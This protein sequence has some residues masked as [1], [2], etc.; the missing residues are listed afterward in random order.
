MFEKCEAIVMRTIDY[1]ETNKIVTLFTREWGKVA[2]MA[3]GAKKPSSRL[4]AVTQP[5]A[6]GHYLIRRSR[7]VGVLHQGELIDSMRALR[8][9]LFAAAYA[10]Y[11]VEL[12]DKSTEEQKRN[13]YLFELLRQT[14]QYMSEG[15]DL[16]IMALIYEMKM[17]PV[18]GIPPVLDRCARCGA[19]EGSV[20]F[21]VK[22]AGFLCHRCEEADPHR[23]PLSPASARLLRLFFHIDLAR[24]GAIS[25]KETTKAE[26]KAVLS[27]YYDEYAGLSLKA[28]RFLQQMSV[29][30][31]TL[32]PDSGQD[33]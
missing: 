1:G 28:K 6:Y 9:D 5:L 25:V 15:R 11:I 22:E 7:G 12:T 18:L 8:E 3:R 24:L 10:A 26:L 2:V 29:L 30:K 13:P 32:A 20:S 33:A 19:T 23:M 21:S 27:A 16:E 17:L 14:L 4:S 31:D